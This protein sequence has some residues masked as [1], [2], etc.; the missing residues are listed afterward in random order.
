MRKSRWK[1]KRSKS[2]ESEVKEGCFEIRSPDVNR[3]RGSNDR[4]VRTRS[5]KIYFHM[6]NRPIASELF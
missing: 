3:G 1:G 4:G 2:E 5:Y 6:I